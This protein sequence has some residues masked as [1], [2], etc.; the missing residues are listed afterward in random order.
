[1]HEWGG[2]MAITSAGVG[3]GLDLESIISTFV[4]AERTPRENSL[5]KREYRLESEISGV[6]T[7][8]AAV[9]KFNDILAKLADSSQLVK[10]K[11]TI[12]YQGSQDTNLPFSVT[13]SDLVARGSFQV[14]VDALAKGSQLRSAALTLDPSVDPV[15]SGNLT[16]TAGTNTFQVAVDPADSLEDIR[17]KINSAGD[18]FGVQANIINTDA[19]PKLVYNSEITGTGNDL[20]VTN[21]NSSLDAISTAMIP[22]QSAQDASI[23]LDGEVI[24]SS[25]NKFSNAISGLNIEVTA[26]TAVGES[27]T[28][29]IANDGDSA[30]ELIQSFV[31][32]YNELRDQLKTLGDPKTGLLAFDPSVRQLQSQLSQLVAGQ[33]TDAPTGLQ[34]L[35]ELGITI[36]NTGTMAIS[37]TAIG[38]SS[39]RE[40]LD[41][42][43][44]NN[45]RG[46]G[47]LFAGD[48]G[49][50]KKMAALADN[51][52]GTDG[53]L[54]ERSQTLEAE[55][56]TIETK[57]DELE[58][59]LTDYESTLR[60]RYTALDTVM[61]QYS[62]T[63]SYL[64]SIFEN[65]NANNK[66]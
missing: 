23:T 10:N 15:G 30:E 21:D 22:T 8:K 13:T 41:A 25:T 61:A 7:L 16:F 19:G 1:M 33:N 45:I 6:G 17:D 54:I 64:T 14:T 32:G 63:S 50:A 24:T 20:S 66:K 49:I 31:D 65:M 27:A 2:V 36:D 4:S 47:T 59:Y 56:T 5:N 57:R 28:L 60:K 51:Y 58:A 53:F 29:A 43:L 12:T 26:E 46:I 39:G 62:A 35:Y 34:S 42:A 18:N 38:S 37:S 44:A 3:S 48:N 9:A 11:T 55:R 40:R 52:V